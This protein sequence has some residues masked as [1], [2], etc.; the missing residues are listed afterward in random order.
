MSV[1]V[2]KRQYDSEMLEEQHKRIETNNKRFNLFNK[3][4]IEKATKH[5]NNEMDDAAEEFYDTKKDKEKDDDLS[6]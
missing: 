6:L 1:D 3:R 2:Y 4:D 5:L